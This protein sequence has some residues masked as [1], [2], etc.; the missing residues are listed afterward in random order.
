MGKEGAIGYDGS[1]FYSEP[2]HA[3]SVVDTM[4][5]GDAFLCVTAPFACAGFSMP[6]LL[7]IGNAA[8][9]VKVGV[10]GHQSSVTRA[11]LE[12]YL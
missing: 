8:G 5:A 7:K 9:A 11:A 12:E 3:K 10:V 6:D 1:E 2:T 4:G